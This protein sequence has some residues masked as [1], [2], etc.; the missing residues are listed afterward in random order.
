VYIRNDSNEDP[1][2]NEV[3]AQAEAY[4]LQLVIDSLPKR[5]GKSLFETVYGLFRTRQRQL[6][7]D[8]VARLREVILKNFDSLD[9]F[10]REDLLSN[11]WDQIKD[12]SLEPSIERLLQDKSYP[13][14]GR[15]NVKGTGLKRLR[16]LDSEK[17]RQYMVAEI[18]DPRSMLY[19][20][21]LDVFDGMVLPETDQTTLQQ[22]RQLARGGSSGVNMVRLRW[23][24]EVAARF[25]SD[26][27]YES[28]LDIYRQYSSAWQPDTKGFLLGYFARYKPSDALQLVQEDLVR[29]GGA[30]FDSLLNAF[31]KYTY[32]REVSEFFDRRLASSDPRIAGHAAYV[33]SEHGTDKDRSKLESRL[34]ALGSNP[35]E[36]LSGLQTELVMSLLRGKAWTLSEEDKKNLRTFCTTQRCK[37]A[38]HW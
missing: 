35:D 38:F 11:L 3:F 5:Q 37:D 7:P 21:V 34:E 27:I 28:L 18:N 31:V 1:V 6:S 10:S 12:P 30:L 14:Y 4:Y 15:I 29:T 36:K 22:I 17:A 19:D 25:S 33:I 24:C 16:E 20:E 23:R 8:M 32:P 26:S 9:A 13:D 2:Q